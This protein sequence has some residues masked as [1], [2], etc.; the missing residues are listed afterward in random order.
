MREPTNSRAIG[1]PNR[2]GVRSA[3]MARSLPRRSPLRND[4]NV[5]EEAAHRDQG[6]EHR[7]VVVCARRVRRQLIG[8]IGGCVLNFDESPF[9]VPDDLSRTH[10]LHPVPRSFVRRIICNLWRYGRSMQPKLSISTA[11]TVNRGL[12]TSPLAR[13]ER[14]RSRKTGVPAE[15]GGRRDV[16]RGDHGG[17]TRAV[18]VTA[19]RETG[20]VASHGRF[21]EKPYG[22]QVRE[23]PGLDVVGEREAVKAGGGIGREAGIIATQLL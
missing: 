13:I 23:Q 16:R 20:S 6:D 9:D 11:V 5:L 7:L 19:W 22:A 17:R 21:A 8:N 15:D 12:T 2:H 10:E 1:G 3:G 14:G 4:Q 18:G